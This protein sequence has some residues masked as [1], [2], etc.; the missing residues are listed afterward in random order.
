MRYRAVIF[1][2]LETINQDPEQSLQDV[3]LGLSEM[4]R[5]A[6]FLDGAQIGFILPTDRD[7]PSNAF[8]SVQR[9][10]PS[11]DETIRWSEDPD[12]RRI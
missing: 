3:H 10:L 5:D 9:A 2:E 6:A 8:W 4:F 12:G 7:G 1:V 11:P